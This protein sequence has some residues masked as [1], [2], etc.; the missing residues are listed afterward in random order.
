MQK[1]EHSLS[2]VKASAP[3]THMEASSDRNRVPHRRMVQTHDTALSDA[4]VHGKS[5]LLW[6]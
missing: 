1:E 4:S 6:L 3:E 2:Y 5:V